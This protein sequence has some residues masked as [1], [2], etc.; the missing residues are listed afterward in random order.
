MIFLERYLRSILYYKLLGVAVELIEQEFQKSRKKL[1]EQVYSIIRN[2][3][4][5]VR[6]ADLDKIIGKK[7]DVRFAITRL[8]ASGKIS[9]RKGLGVNGIEYFYHDNWSGKVLKLRGMELPRF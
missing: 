8:T 6:T 1:I 7:Q 9:R 3:S 5:K 4:G 2:N